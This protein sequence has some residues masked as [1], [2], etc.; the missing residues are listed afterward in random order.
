[1]PAAHLFAAVL[2]PILFIL[3]ANDDMHKSSKEFEI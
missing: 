3:S 1:M 2:H